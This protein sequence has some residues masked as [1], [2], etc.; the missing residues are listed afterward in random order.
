MTLQEKHYDAIDSCYVDK[1]QAAIEC[2][3]IYIEYAVEILNKVL[4]KY[5]TKN[6]R[7]IFQ[8]LASKGKFI[9]ID[10]VLVEQKK[11]VILN[12]IKKLIDDTRTN[13]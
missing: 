9:T 3:K 2:T 7:S 12:E 6:A 8:A 4:K 13:K 5:K 11:Q 1:E 10:E